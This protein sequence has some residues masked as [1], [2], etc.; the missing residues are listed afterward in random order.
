MPAR[1]FY[2]HQ[3]DATWT[4][5]RKGF[6]AFLEQ[7]AANG[8]Y[9]LGDSRFAATRLKG[10]GVSLRDGVLMVPDVMHGRLVAPLDWDKDRFAEELDRFR[11]T[12]MVGT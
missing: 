12:G 9:D 5:P 8:A 1:R 7:G 2:V 3:Y 4:L 10:G 11:K 6:E